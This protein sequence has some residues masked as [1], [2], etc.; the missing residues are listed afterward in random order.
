MDS[1]INLKNSDSEDGRQCASTSDI[2][3]VANE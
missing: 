1:T 2:P 3:T